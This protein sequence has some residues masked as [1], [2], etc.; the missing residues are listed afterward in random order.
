MG[1]MTLT[2]VGIAGTGAVG[3]HVALRLCRDEVPGYVL[4][5][6]AARNETRA[7]VFLEGLRK[8]VPHLTFAEL[9]IVCDV[10]VE[11]LPP[12]LFEDIARP[13]LAAGRSLVALSAS[14]LIGRDD[15]IDLARETGARILVPSGAILGLDALKA[16]AEGTLHSVTI[17]TRK[18]VASLA[19][20][21]YL[22][23]AGIDPA[24]I[25]EPT[26]I[27]A[28]TVTEVAREFPANVNV[29]AA[30]SL[31]GIGPDQTRMEVWADPGITRNTHTVRVE[32]D[33]S[34]FTVSIQNRPSPD[35]PATGIITA[36]SVIA[37][38]RD[39]HSNLRLGT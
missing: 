2:K 18:P 8:P 14:Q 23:K 26:C 38:L 12:D 34:D 17:E 33:S 24:A 1:S 27:L 32:S 6:F 22:A 5:G 28:G 35:N 10:V 16:A 29:A 20:A 19:K 31:A 39:I 15:L 30:I 36:Q 3:R 25:T 11:C 7:A 37:L 13:V 21:P 4:G 9:S